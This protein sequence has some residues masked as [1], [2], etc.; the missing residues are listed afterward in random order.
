MLL[1]Y[2]DESGTADIPGN[3]SH[4]ILAG[5]AV[6]V[7]YWRDCDK[8]IESVKYIIET[9]LF[10]DSQLTGM[11]QIADLCA[12]ALRRYF[13]NIESQLFDM[14]F[15]RADQKDGKVVSVRHFTKQNCSC[16]VCTA[17]RK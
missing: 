15:Q 13:E 1:C 6:P 12:Y 2:I 17:H 16:K 8:A 11:V 5:L 9:P 3:T 7:R 10:V 14:V 4:Y